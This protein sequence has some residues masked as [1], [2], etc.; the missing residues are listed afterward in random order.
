MGYFY[1]VCNLSNFILIGGILCNDSVAVTRCPLQKKREHFDITFPKLIFKKSLCGL[2]GYFAFDTELTVH[3]AIGVKVDTPA[4]WRVPSSSRR[5][6]VRRK[7]AVLR[8]HS[9]PFSI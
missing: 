3:V 8:C 7:R 1:H 5:I 4:F 6:F 9:P 2:R